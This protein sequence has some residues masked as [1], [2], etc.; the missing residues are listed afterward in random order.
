MVAVDDKRQVAAVLTVPPRFLRGHTP[1]LILAHSSGADKDDPLFRYLH[2][3][4]AA[5]GFLTVRF[6]FPYRQENRKLPDREDVLEATFR[7][8]MEHVRVHPRWAPGPL[9][10]GGKSL[11]GR[12]ATHLAAQGAEVRGLVLLAYP[13]QPPGRPD[14]RR[15]QH[16]TSLGAPVLFMSGTRDALAPRAILEATVARVPRSTM[17]WLEQGDHSFRVPRSTGLAAE[18]VHRRVCETVAD[19]MDEVLA[20]PPP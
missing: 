8:V 12:M 6:N 4:L 10:A 7:R 18:D 11:G 3:F 19:W 2:V 17:R 14:K 20:A 1:A 5:R 9:F 15:D 16:L 13:L